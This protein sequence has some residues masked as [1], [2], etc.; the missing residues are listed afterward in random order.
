MTTKIKLINV[1]IDSCNYL[2]TECVCV[3]VDTLKIYSLGKFQVYDIVL[4]TTATMI[5]LI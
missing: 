5:V 4:L 2:V 3:C 1:S